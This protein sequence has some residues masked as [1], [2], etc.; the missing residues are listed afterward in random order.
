ME[1]KMKSSWLKYL[2]FLGMLGVLG[3]FT[4]NIGFYGFFG[5]FG[6]FIYSKVIKDERLEANINKAARNAF[7]VAVP[8]FV[9]ATVIAGIMKDLSV[10]SYAFIV[11]FI[12]QLLTFSFS[13]KFYEKE[14][15]EE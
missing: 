14:L 4:D 1:V 6:F 2:G 3:I 11:L 15:R 12:L 10:Y 8:I 9:I 7:V 5:F 13:L